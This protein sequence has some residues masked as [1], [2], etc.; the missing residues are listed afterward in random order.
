VLVNRTG[1]GLIAL[2]LVGGAAMFASGFFTGFD[3]V[4]SGLWG[5]GA[6]WI[7]VSLGLLGYAIRG[8]LKARKDDELVRNGIKG[9][10]EILGLTA[11]GMVVNEQ[12]MMNVRMRLEAPGIET[13]EVE[14]QSLVPSFAVAHI[15]RDGGLTL[16]AYFDPR[17]PDRY[18]VAW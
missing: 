1:K 13:R 10:A 7:V 2:F 6:I 14:K 5:T 11:S 18:L 12:P 8:R 16:P 15:Q 4:F 3:F 9:R 17:N